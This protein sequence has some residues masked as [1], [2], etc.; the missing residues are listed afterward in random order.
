LPEAIRDQHT[1]SLDYLWTPEPGSDNNRLPLVLPS[2][3]LESLEISTN[4]PDVISLADDEVL[5]RKFSRQFK[6]TWYT[7]EHPT[8]VALHLPQALHVHRSDVPSICLVETHIDPATVN[9]TTTAF[10]ETPPQ[11]VLFRVPTDVGVAPPTVNGRVAEATQIEFGPMDSG[12]VYRITMPSDLPNDAVQVS[13]TCQRARSPHH[14]LLSKE[15]A[16]YPRIVD[17]PDWLTVVWTVGTSDNEQMVSLD[18]RRKSV[19][20]HSMTDTFLKSSPNRM[21]PLIETTLTSF[22]DSVRDLFRRHLDDSF[23]SKHASLA[24]I[25]GPELQTLSVLMYSRAMGWVAA[26]ALGVLF[27]TALISFRRYLR[28][29]AAL[30]VPLCAVAWAALPQQALTLLFPIFP[31]VMIA[32][33]AW[34]VR[35][36]LVPEGIRRRSRHRQP[37]IFTSTPRTPLQISVTDALS[38]SSSSAPISGTRPAVP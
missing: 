25:A 8:H 6:A 18:G 35:Q 21:S 10:Y 2:Q 12:K 11:T 14:H 3:G 22:P 38:S 19:F 13:L 33:I 32:T 30:L 9:T 17:A 31:A 4:D 1:A 26:A 20:D 27:Y 5:H 23:I 16:T 7:N 15:V 34:L 29:I 24:F 28:S 37:S 36:L